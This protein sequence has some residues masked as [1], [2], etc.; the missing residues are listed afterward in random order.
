MF[1]SS[2]SSVRSDGNV[3]FGRLL[4]LDAEALGVADN[5]APESAPAILSFDFDPPPARAADHVGSWWDG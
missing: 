2:K 3:I 1:E 4:A 5:E